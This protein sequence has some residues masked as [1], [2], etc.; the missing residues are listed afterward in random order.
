MTLALRLTPADAYSFTELTASLPQISDKVLTQ[1]LR[2]LVSAGLVTRSTTNGFLQRTE[3]RVTERGEKLR[4]LLI[5][6]YRTGLML[7]S[8][9][10]AAERQQPETISPG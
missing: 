5:E 2:E 7:Q 9:K 1:R 4:P 6:L 3:Y 8:H 10:A